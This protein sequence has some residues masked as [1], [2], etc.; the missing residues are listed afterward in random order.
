MEISETFPL[1]G[2]MERLV[3]QELRQ[4]IKK[5]MRNKL[6]KIV[7]SNYGRLRKPGREVETLIRVKT[8]QTKEHSCVKVGE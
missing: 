1:Y 8:K 2:I 7:S 4:G 5:N 3:C 6:V